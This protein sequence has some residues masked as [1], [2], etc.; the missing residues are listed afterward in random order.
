MRVETKLRTW[1]TAYGLMLPAMAI[2]VGLVGY[3]IIQAIYFSL[4]NARVGKP[5]DF[6]GLVNYADLLR[7]S[8]FWTAL[9]NSVGFTV[10]AVTL[11]LAFGLAIAILLNQKHLGNRWIRGAILLPWVIPS[12]FGVV[13]WLWILNYNLGSLNWLLQWLGVIHAPIPWLADPTYAR[14][15]V[16]LV[17]FW[18]GLPFFAITLLAGLVAIPTELY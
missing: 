9:V 16:V 6:V 18:R 2:I 1:I 15:S 10:V 14:V 7:N 11:K 3:P 8:V 4:T 17:N 12:T 13:A 5:G